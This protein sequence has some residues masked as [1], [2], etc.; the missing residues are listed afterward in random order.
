MKSE[1][2]VTWQPYFKHPIDNPKSYGLLTGRVQTTSLGRVLLQVA[3]Y[4]EYKY[5]DQ[6]NNRHWQL[7]WI[8]EK[9]LLKVQRQDVPKEAWILRRE[10]LG[11][12]EWDR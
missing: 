5:P 2:W 11:V 7:R 6:V 1:Q 9:S 8:S 4:F 12:W 10:R 3:F